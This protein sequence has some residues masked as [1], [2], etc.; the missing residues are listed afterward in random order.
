MITVEADFITTYVEAVTALV[1][2]FLPLISATI[3]IFLAFGIAN[4]LRFFIHK[5]IKIR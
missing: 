4:M 1:N 3:G 5:T 2:A